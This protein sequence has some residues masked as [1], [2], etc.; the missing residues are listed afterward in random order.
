[1][2]ESMVLFLSIVYSL[3]SPFFRVRNCTWTSVLAG[4]EH[5]GRAAWSQ[6]LYHLVLSHSRSVFL[7][8]LL[9]YSSVW[10]TFVCITVGTTMNCARRS[11]THTHLHLCSLHRAMMQLP[12]NN[13]VRIGNKDIYFLSILTLLGEP[14]CD[15]HNALQINIFSSHLV[16]IQMPEIMKLFI[17]TVI[18]CIFQ[19]LC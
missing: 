9:A 14:R 6:Y 3:M 5:L 8:L 18:L 7:C 13:I 1:M 17:K 11:H 2:I 19:Q 10:S 15:Y 4:N 12:D 16:L